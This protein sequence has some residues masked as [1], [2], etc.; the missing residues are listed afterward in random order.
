MAKLPQIDPDGLKFRRKYLVPLF[1]N[2][3]GYW[4]LTKVAPRIDAR[5]TPLTRGWISS[6]PATPLLLM[7]HIGAKSGLQRT[8]PLMY[9]SRNDDVIV[10]ASNYGRDKHPAWLYNVIANPDVTLEFRGR[11]GHYRARVAEGAERDE[12]WE[13]AKRF[14]ANYADYE[15]RAGDREIQ[16]VVCEYAD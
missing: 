9:F 5:M 4:Y 11:T 2:K 15:Q 3:A 12:L 16:I 14:I 13:S 10:M 8:T 6:A 7:T 1:N